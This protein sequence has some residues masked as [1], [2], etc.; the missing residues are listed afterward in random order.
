MRA[1]SL[2]TLLLIA[3]AGCASTPPPFTVS[4]LGGESTFRC[5]TTELLA[6][7]YAVD[8]SGTSAEANRVERLAPAGANRN[9]VALTVV[10]GPEGTVQADVRRWNYSPAL[11]DLP[12][13]RQ[14]VQPVSVDDETG[15]ELSR[16][17]RTCEGAREASL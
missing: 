5:A 16:I 7:G 6:A 12:V 13:E 3:A 17:M 2:A 14:Q 4:A 10:D 11:H 15:T 8:V 9:V 1:A